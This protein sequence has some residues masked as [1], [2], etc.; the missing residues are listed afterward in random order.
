[1]HYDRRSAERLRARSDDNAM[2]WKRRRQAMRKIRLYPKS[3]PANQREHIGH[4]STGSRA[5][6]LIAAGCVPAG[7]GFGLATRAPRRLGLV[8]GRV[9]PLRPPLLG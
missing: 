5:D 8:R 2:A 9:R 6:L 3:P 7:Q 4:V 1:M